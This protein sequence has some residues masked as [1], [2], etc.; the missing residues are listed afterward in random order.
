MPFLD[1]LTEY[2]APWGIKELHHRDRAEAQLVTEIP[3]P[4]SQARLERKRTLVADG[5]GTML[6]V[7]VTA[8]GGGVLLD[9]DGN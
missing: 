8:A 1:L 3:G 5:V 6:P 9:V 4:E 2:G 7:F